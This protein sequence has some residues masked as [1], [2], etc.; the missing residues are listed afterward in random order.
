MPDLS[1]RRFARIPGFALKKEDI[2]CK[3]IFN[4]YFQH[5]LLHLE[6]K[7]QSPGEHLKHISKYYT[8]TFV[9]FGNHHNPSHAHYC[10]LESIPLSNRNIWKQCAC[11]IHRVPMNM[12]S[13][14]QMGKVYNNR[15]YLT[16]ALSINEQQSCQKMSIITSE[17]P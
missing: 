11:P 6:M 8:R 10:K 14:F 2:D 16:A 7:T 1:F 12:R 9:I 13:N 17:P 15:K 5:Q 4:M 3:L